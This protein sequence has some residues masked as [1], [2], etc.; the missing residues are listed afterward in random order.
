MIG[1]RRHVVSRR[2]AIQC[3]PAII[4]T[5]FQIPI[6]IEV[7]RK[8]MRRK[9]K[10]FAELC[11]RRVAGNFR[12]PTVTN[13][14]TATWNLAPGSTDDYNSLHWTGATGGGVPVAADTASVTNGGTATI[15]TGDS[16]STHTT[17][18]G[19]TRLAQRRELLF[20]PAEQLP[21]PQFVAIGHGG[22]NGFYIF[23]GGNN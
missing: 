9:S 12:A 16:I 21:R 17:L 4:G 1:D 2:P 23:S 3:A 13:A 6:Q 7:E 11:R 14:A 15:S 5:S 20:N 8:N 22:S 19:A 18:G 10:L